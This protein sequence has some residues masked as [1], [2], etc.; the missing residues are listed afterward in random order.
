MQCRT[1]VARQLIVVV[2]VDIEHWYEPGRHLLGCL[3]CICAGSWSD[4]FDG[5]DDDDDDHVMMMMMMM[6]VIVSK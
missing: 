5:D 4:R 3:I 1:S 6:I 2:K